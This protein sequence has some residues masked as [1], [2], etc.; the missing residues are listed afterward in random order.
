MYQSGSGRMS[1]E[2]KLCIA[3]SMCLIMTLI[4]I[5]WL[6]YLYD[7]ERKKSKYYEYRI[8]YEEE[9]TKYYAILKKQKRVIFKKKL[10]LFWLRLLVKVKGV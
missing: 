2:L 6:V 4:L 7:S 3:V 9:L 8:T 5:F 10:Q 1:S